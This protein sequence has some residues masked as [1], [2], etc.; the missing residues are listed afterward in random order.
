[1]KRLTG[2]LVIAAFLLVLVPDTV[3]A[4]INSRV[5]DATYELTSCSLPNPASTIEES[6]KRRMSLWEMGRIAALQMLLGMLG[7]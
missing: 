3:D 1:M 7:G 6:P 2:I 4:G 5:C